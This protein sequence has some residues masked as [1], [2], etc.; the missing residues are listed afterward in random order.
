MD[1]STLA[2]LDAMIVGDALGDIPEPA[3]AAVLALLLGTAL[4]ALH[5][6]QVVRV[7]AFVAC[8]LMW[9]RANHAFEGQVLIVFSTEHGLTTADLVP[10]G[11]ALAI[12]LR[13][14]PATR[15]APRP[16]P[17]TP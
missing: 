2:A 15:R 17:A 12:V 7:V 11:L 6:P 3:Q 13:S 4:W 5:R 8:A 1:H 14:W 9:S 16:Q 10:S